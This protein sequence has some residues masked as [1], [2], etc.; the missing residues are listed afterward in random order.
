M[1]TGVLVFASLSA[2][3]RRAQRAARQVGEEP[4]LRKIIAQDLAQ[5]WPAY[6][7]FTRQP[8]PGSVSIGHSGWRIYAPSH[9]AQR[10]LDVA[11]GAFLGR[12]QELA[13]PPRSA[14]SRFAGWRG[15]RNQCPA[16]YWRISL[17]LG[18][19]WNAHHKP[20]GL[21]DLHALMTR[22][23]REKCS[24]LETHLRIVGAFED[25]N[26]PN[27][28][29]TH[30]KASISRHNINFHA[31]HPLIPIVGRDRT[32]RSQDLCTRP[33]S[34]LPAAAPSRSLRLSC[35]PQSAQ[36]FDLPC[37]EREHCRP[38]LQYRVLALLRFNRIS[39]RLAARFFVSLKS[40]VLHHSLFLA[41]LKGTFA[42]P[43][44]PET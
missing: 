7:V 30:E 38:F 31:G 5:S 36:V 42:T 4:C 21:P 3:N 10:F 39:H 37:F 40:C 44:Q 11:F 20:A 33:A 2:R 9:E 29:A 27:T 8:T 34:F 22:I 28:F 12:T 32:L 14:G 23:S 18:A 26:R 15:Q 25:L 17:I 13:P 35:Q 19:T 43:G 24:G 1:S 41:R 6:S 16:R